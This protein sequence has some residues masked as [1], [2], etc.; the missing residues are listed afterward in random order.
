MA[1]QNREQRTHLT[2]AFAVLC[3]LFWLHALAPNYPAIIPAA[4]LG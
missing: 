2:E 4:S 1:E 3:P